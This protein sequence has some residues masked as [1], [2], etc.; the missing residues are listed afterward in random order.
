L[1]EVEQEFFGLRRKKAENR[2]PAVV[3]G[4]AREAGL[5]NFLRE[6]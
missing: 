5:G 6:G 1:N 4:P 3:A 2:R